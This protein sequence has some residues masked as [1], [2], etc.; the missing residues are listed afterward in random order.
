MLGRNLCSLRAEHLLKGLQYNAERRV[1]VIAG[2]NKMK[3]SSFL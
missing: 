3:S 2:E 1:K